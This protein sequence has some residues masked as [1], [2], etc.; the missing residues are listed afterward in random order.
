ML[1]CVA[2]GIKFRKISIFPV[3]D[4]KIFVQEKLK[5]IRPR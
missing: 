4:F 3:G 2:E 5:V 1:V